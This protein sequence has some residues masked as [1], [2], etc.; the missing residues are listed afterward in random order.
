MD[1]T[2]NKNVRKEKKNNVMETEQGCLNNFFSGVASFDGQKFHGTR[3]PTVRVWQ[4]WIMLAA[5]IVTFVAYIT[6]IFFFFDQWSNNDNL[7]FRWY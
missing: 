6:P 2:Y 4:M 1:Y 5:I 7:I 3:C